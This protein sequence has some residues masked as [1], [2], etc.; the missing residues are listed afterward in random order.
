MEACASGTPSR[1]GPGAVFHTEV[2]MVYKIRPVNDSDLNSLLRIRN[3]EELF[4]RYLEQHDKGEVCFIVAENNGTIIGFE[5]L[6]LSGSP[7]PKLSDLYVKETCRGS[8][9]G[10]DLIKYHE[11]LART[12][13]C[14]DLF[15]SVDP[16]ENPRMIRLI[17]RL[18]YKAITDPYLKTAVFYNEDG[19]SYET[20]YTRIDLKK[21]LN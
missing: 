5:V 21:A 11:N 17:T 19:T 13:S 15:V 4:L 1:F 8:G 6:K 14:P 20:T 12:L 10:S 3:H 9:V 16:I 7:S 2:G 18:G